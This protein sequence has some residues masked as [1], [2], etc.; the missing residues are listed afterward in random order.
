MSPNMA[1]ADL[2]LQ[3]KSDDIEDPAAKNKPQKVSLRFRNVRWGY[4]SFWTLFLIWCQFLLAI[5]IYLI[6]LSTYASTEENQN[7]GTCKPGGKFSP[8]WFGSWSYWS[9]GGF[10]EI[11]LGSGKFTFTEAKVIDIFWDLLVGRGG[12]VVIAYL[13][14]IALSN[15]IAISIQKSPISYTTF[16][17]TFLHRE[18]TLL[19]VYRLITDR[20]FY[21]ALRSK[22]AI[23]FAVISLIFVLSFPT[24][25]D[26]MTGYV[27]ATTPYVQEKSSEN[28]LVPFSLFDEVAFIIHDGWRVNGT[29]NDIIPRDSWYRTH[30]KRATTVEKRSNYTVTL[31]K[32]DGPN[33]GSCQNSW[34]VV[35]KYVETY[36]SYMYGVNTKVED[37]TLFNGQPV[38]WPPL[39][40]SVWHIPNQFGDSSVPWIDPTTGQSP[41]QNMNATSPL[42]VYGNYTYTSDEIISG[43]RCQ[44][45][46]DDAY[47]WGFSFLQLFIVLMLLILWTIG[48]WTMWFKAHLNRPSRLPKNWKRLLHLTSTMREELIASGIDPKTLTDQQ[49]AA[50]IQ[51][52]LNGGQVFASVREEPT[53][54]SIRQHLLKN[55]KTASWVVFLLIFHIGL[56][57]WYLDQVIGW[58]VDYNS[59]DLPW[60]FVPMLVVWWFSFLT[61]YILSLIGIRWQWWGVYLLVAF[62]A[63]FGAAIVPYKEL[64]L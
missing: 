41:P 30:D 1:S 23:G 53:S 8:W 60:Q 56:L 37:F 29:G 48:T 24:L 25:A 50:H 12:Q 44:P 19:N 35:G 49:L 58:A 55:W 32:C 34:A 14:W 38:E 61:F 16:W 52:R 63:N 33:I 47:Q 59:V 3:R 22:I 18:S 4:Y 13:S 28:L 2:P 64:Y 46:S 43:G 11:T 27:P 45:I 36:G 26:S 9:D 42:F 40:I 51:E 62:G 17:S 57:V 20:S 54:K 10:F 5:F 21:R 6:I 7:F 31:G 15:F 39:R